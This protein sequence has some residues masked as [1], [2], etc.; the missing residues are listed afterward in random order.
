[1]KR[2][3]M[4][5]LVL[6]L[7]ALSGGFADDK[8]DEKFDASKIT[9]TWV[10]TSGTKYGEAVDK[11][12]TEGTIVIDKEKIQI[13]EGD[14]V[15]HEMTYKID[16]KH[17]PAHIDMKGTV[18]PA[19]DLSAEGIIELSGDTLKLCYSFPGEKRPAKFES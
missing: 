1:M 10:I 9:G 16:A 17:S 12:S 13:K 7:A 18:G 6:G 4:L 19:K 14:T 2:F 3:G 8:K 11:K 5:A 15:A